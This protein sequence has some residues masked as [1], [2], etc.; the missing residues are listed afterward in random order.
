M[1]T[2]FFTPSRERR[3]KAF[4]FVASIVEKYNYDLWDIDE[5]G[6]ALFHK[7]IYIPL[8]LRI[9]LVA[10][11]KGSDLIDSM[12]VIHFPTKNQGMTVHFNG[13]PAPQEIIDMSY[14]MEEQFH[15]T[16]LATTFET[17]IKQ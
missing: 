2:E 16:E 1:S 5:K 8:E 15:L 7:G 6:I 10:K 17:F 4:E 14:E 11:T 13:T 3:H 12:M 9:G